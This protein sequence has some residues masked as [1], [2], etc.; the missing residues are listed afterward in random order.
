MNKLIKSIFCI[1][2]TTI[3]FT[4]CI[5]TK[6]I[7]KSDNQNQNQKKQNKKNQHKLNSLTQNSAFSEN[8]L[9]QKKSTIYLLLNKQP[10]THQRPTSL[11]LTPQEDIKLKDSEKPNAPSREV[12]PISFYPS[13]HRLYLHFHLKQVF[14]HV[15]KLLF[16]TFPVSIVVRHD[17]IKRNRHII[18]TQL[19]FIFQP[20][21]SI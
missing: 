4:S 3:I 15:G 17:R 6:K 16:S 8:M 10:S 20:V 13:A 5:S 7:N 9:T 12:L 18:K 19:P 2:I 21:F 11:F 1:F 14:H